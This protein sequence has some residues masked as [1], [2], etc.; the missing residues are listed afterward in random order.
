MATDESLKT[1]SELLVP[2]IFAVM[3]EVFLLKICRI[4]VK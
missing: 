2:T 4:T 1:K 3:L